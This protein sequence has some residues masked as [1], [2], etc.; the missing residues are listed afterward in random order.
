MDGYANRTRK[1]GGQTERR[2]GE[3]KLRR[4]RMRKYLMGIPAIAVVS[5]ALPCLAESLLEWI[6]YAWLDRIPDSILQN[7]VYLIFAIYAGTVACFRG[8]KLRRKIL[9]LVA[10]FFV[11]TIVFV[12]IFSIRF[13]MAMASFDP[14]PG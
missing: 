2:R 7:T 10:L 6:P 4:M 3:R 12:L 14:G 9:I 11:Q 1:N 5:V 8:E 13:G